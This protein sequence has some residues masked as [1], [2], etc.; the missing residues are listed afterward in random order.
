[1]KI[2]RRILLTY[3]IIDQNFLWL[4]NLLLCGFTVKN[5]TTLTLS[6]RCCDFPSSCQ[7]FKL[8][9]YVIMVALNLL[10]VRVVCIVASTVSFRITPTSAVILHRQRRSLT[11][12]W[13]EDGVVSSADHLPRDSLLQTVES[14]LDT[15]K[16]IML[17]A[18][19][20]T[21]KTSLLDMLKERT[22]NKCHYVDLKVPGSSRS[23]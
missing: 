20:G 13:K 6:R 16:V 8:I 21:G 19:A 1:M 18:T 7:Y 23:W 9:A 11:A 12:V 15:E 14:M 22:P 2:I 4:E 5:V 3:V 17:S 10:M